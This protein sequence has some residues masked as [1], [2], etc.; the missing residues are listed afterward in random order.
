MNNALR[1]PEARESQSLRAHILKHKSF[2]ALLGMLWA[3]TAS[4]ALAVYDL[5][6]FSREEWAH[7]RN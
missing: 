7:Y 4:Q 3:N 5:S 2:L 1:V 6:T